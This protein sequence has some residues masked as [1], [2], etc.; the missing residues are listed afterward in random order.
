MFW[1]GRR[2]TSWFWD[3]LFWIWLLVPGSLGFLH[4]SWAA[5]PG[6]MVPLFIEFTRQTWSFLKPL[7]SLVLILNDHF[8][9]L[10][11]A[12]ISSRWWKRGKTNILSCESSKAM[13]K[14]WILEPNFSGEFW[15]ESKPS[16]NGR[17]RREKWT[18]PSG[19]VRSDHLPF[20]SACPF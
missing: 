10:N 7:A 3:L 14:L 4:R 18:S 8:L 19:P 9:D 1:K 11:L 17:G 13:Y 6:W 16:R 20:Q 15:D 12:W 5:Q 2:S